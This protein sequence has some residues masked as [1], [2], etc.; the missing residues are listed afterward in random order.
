ML[1]STLA[2]E[3]RSRAQTALPALRRAG[4]LAAPVARH[5][6]F[7]AYASLAAIVLGAAMM[8]AN[9]AREHRAVPAVAAR[10]VAPVA[11]KAAAVKAAPIKAAAAKPRLDPI[12]AIASP[13]PAL[14]KLAEKIM[15]RIDTTP[16]AS[17]AKEEPAKPKRAPPRHAHKR[18]HAQSER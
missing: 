1:P 16:T 15:Q 13:S 12:A 9:M 8:M 17:I 14:P 7:G 2:D 5:R 18:K 11:V 4:A 6:H 10:V 3:L